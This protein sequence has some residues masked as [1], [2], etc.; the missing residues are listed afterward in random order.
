MS[1]EPFL[2]K[3][4]TSSRMTSIARSPVAR[5]DAMARAIS[6]AENPLSGNPL[7]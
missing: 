2:S 4:S 1:T 5:W 7:S 6:S 3:T